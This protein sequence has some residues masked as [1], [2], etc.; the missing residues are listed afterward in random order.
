MLGRR[1]E[2]VDEKKKLKKKQQLNNNTRAARKIQ[3]TKKSC[4]PRE[5][6]LA[7]KFWIQFARRWNSDLDLFRKRIATSTI[8]V[9]NYGTV[10]H[11]ARGI[12][13][14]LFFI[15]FLSLVAWVV[16]RT[17]IIHGSGPEA[18]Q[19]VLRGIEILRS[20][21]SKDDSGSKRKGTG[22]HWADV[23]VHFQR[24]LVLLVGCALPNC[25]HNRDTLV[26]AAPLPGTISSQ[27][28]QTLVSPLATTPT[29]PS[30]KLCNRL[31]IVK[32]LK[33]G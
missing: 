33:A 11:V 19:N 5:L 23:F 17:E 22:T 2:K 1:N 31:G 6:Q 8:R 10:V 13:R 32:S 28:N 4:E 25:R 26:H 3:M 20:G 24:F 9:E 16:R 30:H 15:F 7:Q 29:A 21:I 12:L 14:F 27:I 18:I